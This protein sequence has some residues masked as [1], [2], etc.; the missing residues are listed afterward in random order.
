MMGISVDIPDIFLLLLG[1]QFVELC[2]HGYLCMLLG[3]LNQFQSYSTLN[4]FI[5]T[6]LN[7]PSGF[8]EDKPSVWSAWFFGVPTL[9]KTY[10]ANAKKTKKAS[11]ISELDI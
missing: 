7:T 10:S 6:F 5:H 9:N 8:Q 2:A 4:Y 1:S 11:S 3:A